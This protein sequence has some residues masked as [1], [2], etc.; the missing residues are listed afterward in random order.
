MA[1]CT[2][3]KNLGKEE[4]ERKTCVFSSRRSVLYFLLNTLLTIKRFRDDL[5]C[6]NRKEQKCAIC[7]IRNEFYSVE[8]N[9]YDNMFD[10]DF[11]NRIHSSLF[12]YLQKL[13]LSHRCV[14][15][16]LNHKLAYVWKDWY[17]GEK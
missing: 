13:I 9:L 11:L 4:F 14:S 3:C 17:N 2:T 12:A 1:E 16:I 10:F 8:Y 6:C 5:C 7:E 15:L